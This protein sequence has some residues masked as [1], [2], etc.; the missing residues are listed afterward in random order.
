M[1]IG[2]EMRKRGLF[3]VFFIKSYNILIVIVVK[4]ISFVNCCWVV[5]GV[6]FCFLYLI[7]MLIKVNLM[8][9]VKIRVIY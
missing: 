2:N 5:Y 9:V 3:N 8:V 6:S 7:I 1:V 4:M